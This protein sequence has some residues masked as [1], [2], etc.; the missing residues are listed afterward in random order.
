METEE[1]VKRVRILPPPTRPVLPEVESEV[2]PMRE[3]TPRSTPA[4]RVSGSHTVAV[5]DQIYSLLLHAKHAMEV[6]ERRLV[7]FGEVLEVM[8]QDQKELRELKERIAAKK[9]A[10]LAAAGGDE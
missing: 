6:E 3:R 5:N 8:A 7:S 4:R 10:R 9:A 1:E 2:P